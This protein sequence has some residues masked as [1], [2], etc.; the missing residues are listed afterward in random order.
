MQQRQNINEGR[1]VCSRVGMSMKKDPS[2]RVRISPRLLPLEYRS[3]L[4]ISKAM[5]L[6]KILIQMRPLSTDGAI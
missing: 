3:Y 1:P 2:S 4:L 6:F 5:T